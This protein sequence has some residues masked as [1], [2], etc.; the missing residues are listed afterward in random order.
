M[1]YGKTYKNYS[2]LFA[3]SLVELVVVAT[4]LAILWTVWFVSYT[5]YISWVRD[6]NRIAQLEKIRSGLQTYAIKSSL[7]E[8]TD[9]ARVMN[10]SELLWYQWYVWQQILE[11]IWLEKWWKD[12]EN[13]S[14]FTYYL[15]K[16]K[17]SFQLLWFLEE[18]LYSSHRWIFQETLA[19]DYFDKYPFVTGQSLWVLTGTGVYKNIPAQELDTVILNDDTIDLWSTTSEFT[20]II[21]DDFI[22]SGDADDLSVLISLS[23][24]KGK[25]WVDCKD[26]LVRNPGLLGLNGEY[27]ISPDGDSTISVVCEMS[28]DGW[29]WTQYS[30]YDNGNY[31]LNDVW[32][33]TKNFNKMFYAYK[34]WGDDMHA[35]EF[36]RFH[37][38]QCGNIYGDKN[39][40]R[41]WIR[42]YID[43]IENVSWG[44]CGRNGTSGDSNDIQI[45]KITNANYADDACINGTLHKQTARNYS[46]WSTSTSDGRTVWRHQHRIS[47]TTVLFWPTGNGSTRC[48]GANSWPSA[49]EVYIYLR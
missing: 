25:L 26:L 38:Q 23:K 4:I 28:Y 20:W 17:L 35:F 14:F 33:L 37:T 3:F 18:G 16:G 44:N 49:S 10:W 36:L 1:K 29:W 15:H 12:P 6:S 2:K 21:R 39:D 43:H 48:A 24:T 5:W 40:L 45:R 30:K 11:S 9:S 46:W 42:D 41:V 19:N 34:R 13:D 31:L 7:P 47:N 32:D 27:I 22:V 8:P